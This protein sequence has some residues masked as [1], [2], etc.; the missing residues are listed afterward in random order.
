MS[1]FQPKSVTKKGNF[2]LFWRVKTDDILDGFSVNAIFKD[3]VD[4]AVNTKIS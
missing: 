2:H 1:F 3:L 4:E